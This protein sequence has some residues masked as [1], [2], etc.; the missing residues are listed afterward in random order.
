MQHLQAGMQ[1]LQSGSL[2][3]AENIFRNILSADSSEVH[4]LHFL[5][6]IF[7]QK[8]NLEDG[9]A[10]I[11]QSI[12][13]DPS[14]FAPYLNMGRFFV[15]ANQWDRALAALQQAV[16]R[17]ASSF[18]A[19]SMLAKASFFSGN[20]DGAL[21]AGKKAAEID[22]GNSEIFFSLG[23]YASGTNKE[24]AIDHYRN[25][26]AIDP[27]SFKAW[28][29]LGNC[30]LDFQRVED[31]IAA[32][33]EAL[34][35]DPS[36]LQA[37]MGLCRAYGD[38]NQW[39]ES[40][41]TAQQALLLNPL[42]HDAA[43][44]VGF[45]LHKLDRK[46]DAVNAYRSALNIT[47]VAAH[48][49]LYLA[50]A[51]EGLSEEQDALNHYEMATKVDPKLSL[52]FT[53]W[54]ALLQK[55][56]D[57]SLAIDKHRRAVEADPSSADAMFGLGTALE[58]DG[59]LDE[60]IVSYRK[61]IEV[62]PDFA[63]AYFN[64][65]NV[66]KEEGKLE[67]AIAI[68]RKAVEVKP[69]FA[70]SYY[71]LYVTHDLLGSSDSALNAL[72]K[73]LQIDP[74]HYNARQSIGFAF[75]K[76]NRIDDAIQY[77]SSR[78]KSFDFVYWVHLF[79]ALEGKIP[80]KL[81]NGVE[82]KNRLVEEILLRIGSSQI[83]A[84]GDSHVNAFRG[85]EGVSTNYLGAATAYNLSSETS[86]SGGGRRLKEKLKTL[87]PET[88]A[89]LLCFGEIDCRAHVVKQAYVANKS[90][91]ESA[92][93]AAKA[94]F[95]LILSIK[96]RGYQV[97]VY[98]PYG[99]GSQF[100]SI[101]LE[102]YRNSAVKFFNNSLRES[103]LKHDI[104]F[105]SLNSF[106]VDPVA[107][108]TRRAWLP[109]DVHLPDEGSLGDQVKVLLLSGLLLDIQ[110]SQQSLVKQAFNEDEHLISNV[111]V[112]GMSCEDKS[113]Y[114]YARLSDAG[115]LKWQ[116][117]VDNSIKTI[118]FDLGSS[119]ALNRAE[120]LLSCGDYSGSPLKF[121]FDGAELNVYQE[122]YSAEGKVVVNF[123]PE[124]IGRFLMISGYKSLSDIR[125]ASF[126]P[127]SLQVE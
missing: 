94:Y 39:V 113:S 77:F 96:E 36:C 62:K 42:S 37:L 126:V 89:I 125:A 15:G 50:T 60:A 18:D 44:K 33:H 98:G 27:A 35:S 69:D 34:K 9:I 55:G 32:F 83:A 81:L 24:E 114:V 38:L 75:F 30:L 19:W 52:A 21:M 51:L 93:D 92:V 16:Q 11:E 3:S 28:V 23:V 7:C 118:C 66:M 6:V 95:D 122:M 88:N 105:F 13:L 49:H 25:A 53:Y 102:S 78:V 119:L 65:G 70:E 47:P 56:G 124:R 73:C 120:I 82:I 45:S 14:R 20:A 10:L 54:G 68:Y 31:A 123:P 8:G 59:G 104:Y 101:G 76:A 80:K 90:I 46:L 87:D 121:L 63:D 103:C 5:G 108:L 85:I 109:D 86:S 84:F 29:N 106:L 117:S 2:E 112:F 127:V 26:V 115:L 110:S 48:T 107:L 91:K 43:F 58:K 41:A 111:C 64:L 17:D 97:I 4:S 12:R 99:S 71:Q 100:N 79:R 57:I 40:L 72:E 22:P 116:S 67:E 61:A 1:A 74:S